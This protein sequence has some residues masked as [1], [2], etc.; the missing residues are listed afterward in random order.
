MAKQQ[1]CGVYKITN[2]QN[3][4]F[5]IGSS[6]DVYH[7]WY[8]HK[9]DLK[10]H[11]HCN[12]YLQNAWDKYGEN[13]FDFEVLEECAPKVQFEREQYYLNTLNPFEENGYN[14]VR[15]ISNQLFSQNYKKSICEYCGEEFFTFSHLA[16]VCDDCK[17][18]RATESWNESKFKAEEKEWFEEMISDAYGSYDDFWESVI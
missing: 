6:K 18:K 3:G 7:R 14:L 10:N 4:K 9:Y 8:E 11:N 17:S 16:K 2:K 12:Q 1:I 5:Y 13:S 15:R